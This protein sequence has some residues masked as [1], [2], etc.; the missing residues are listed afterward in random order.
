MNNFVH[1]I[2]LDYNK[3]KLIAEAEKLNFKPFELPKVYNSWFDYTPTWLQ[4]MVIDG[5]ELPE[6]SRLGSIISAKTGTLDIR[7]RFYRQE[8]NTELPM[9]SDNGTLCSIN[10]I[11]SEEAAP[12]V[13]EEG[14]EF[15]YDCAILNIQERHSVPA[16]PKERFLL[17]YSI[18]DID[19]NEVVKRWNK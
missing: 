6:V 9:H 18:F 12:I 15:S 7:P 11:L 3:E 17:K 13:F 1:N 10:I 5:D 4:G 14:G 19:Y 2:D 8:E 16:Y